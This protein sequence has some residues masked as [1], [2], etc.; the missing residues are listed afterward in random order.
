MRGFTLVELL[1]VLAIIV[2]ITG[3]LFTSRSDFNNT[4]ILSNTAYDIALTIRNMQNYGIGSR[5]VGAVK[6]VGYGVRFASS[7]ADPS[8]KTFFVTFADIYPTPSTDPITRC[9][10]VPVGEDETAPNARPGN[11]V[12][13]ASQSELVQT[14]ALG[15]GITIGNFCAKAGVWTCANA[16]P[17]N[18]VGLQSLDITFVRPNAEMTMMTNGIYSAVPPVT[19]ACIFLASQNGGYR[20]ISINQAGLVRPLVTPCPGL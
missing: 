11:C 16:Y 15:N 5:T 19:E 13:D 20:Y 6:N 18:L 17:P 7:V 2:T 8:L 14:F 3:V 12:Y 9:H 10:P 4:I 1:V